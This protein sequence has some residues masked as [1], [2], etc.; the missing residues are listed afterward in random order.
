M[1]KIALAAALVAAMAVISGCSSCGT[2]SCYAG[3]D[4]SETVE[5]VGVAR[6]AAFADGSTYVTA[7]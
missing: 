5:Y 1:S 7:E 4:S 3:Y 6:P 2:S